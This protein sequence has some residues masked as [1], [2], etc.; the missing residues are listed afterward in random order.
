MPEKLP[1]T[2]IG[3]SVTEEWI[4]VENNDLVADTDGHLLGDKFEPA[5]KS[6]PFI[7]HV[8]VAQDEV[9]FAGKGAKDLFLVARF[10]LGE[11]SQVEDDT[12]LRHGFP[13]APDEL[14]VHL[15][16]IFEGPVAEAYDIFMAKM[17]V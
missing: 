12:V 6:L 1:Y 11:V 3:P 17:S 16:G 7:F 4:V 8:V 15:L 13:P 5:H 14:R 9:F 10:A 2:M